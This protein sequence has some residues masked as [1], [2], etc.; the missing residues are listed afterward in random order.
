MRFLA[1][2]PLLLTVI[3]LITQILAYPPRYTRHRGSWRRQQASAIGDA[4]RKD[5]ELEDKLQ[6]RAGQAFQGLKTK[7]LGLKGSSRNETTRVTELRV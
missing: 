4:Y 7:E 1:P 6:G 3:L 5:G 2:V